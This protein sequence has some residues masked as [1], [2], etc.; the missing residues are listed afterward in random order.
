MTFATALGVFR[1]LHV[2]S[3]QTEAEIAESVRW[4]AEHAEPRT[5]AFVSWMRSRIPALAA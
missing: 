4:R 2:M 5:V 3:R 1:A